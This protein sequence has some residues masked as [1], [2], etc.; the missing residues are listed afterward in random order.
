MAS[1]GSKFDPAFPIR[2]HEPEE[3]YKIAAQH[4]AT[5]GTEGKW[6]DALVETELTFQLSPE[7]ALRITDDP[8]AFEALARQYAADAAAV[9]AAGLIGEDDP[10]D[11]DVTT[12]MP[13][14]WWLK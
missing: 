3:E 9:K 11:D 7:V 1:T 6:I 8:T 13:S 2:R 12:E 5:F 10:R 14:G 4:C